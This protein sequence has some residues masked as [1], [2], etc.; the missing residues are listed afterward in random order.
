[1]NRKK[2]N[3]NNI[4]TLSIM[5]LEATSKCLSFQTP[6]DISK[7]HVKMDS[8]EHRHTLFG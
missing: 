5:R 8:K 6:L 4:L 2:T 1:M 7:R 3:L